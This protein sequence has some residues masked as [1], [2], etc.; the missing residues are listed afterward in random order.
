MK[1]LIVLFTVCLS[2]L[3]VAQQLQT[4]NNGELADAE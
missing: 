2:G 1:N 4:F 3:A